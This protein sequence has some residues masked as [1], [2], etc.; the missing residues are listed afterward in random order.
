LFH[1]D[2]GVPYQG[3]HTANILLSPSLPS[4]PHDPEK[5]IRVSSFC[6]WA[7]TPPADPDDVSALFERVLDKLTRRKLL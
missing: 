5:A 2:M 4:W 6:G 7:C 3:E 1:L